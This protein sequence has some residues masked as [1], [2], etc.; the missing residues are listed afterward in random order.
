MVREVVVGTDGL[1]RGVS[2]IDKKTRSE[3]HCL[4]QNRGA[5]RKLLRDRA[6]HA[7]LQEQPV[8]PTA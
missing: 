3:S 6:D 8:S 7:E 1:A 4:R 2:Y 5:G